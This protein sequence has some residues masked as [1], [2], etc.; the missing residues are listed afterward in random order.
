M[1][2]PG[3]TFVRNARTYSLPRG[4]SSLCALPLVLFCFRLISR[5]QEKPLME[6]DRDCETFAISNDDKIVCAV[7]HV[8]RVKKIVI[9][10]ADVW[11]ADPNGKEKLIVDSE[12]FMPVATPESY[13]V[14]TLAWSPDGSRI[15]MSMTTEK[16]SSEEDRLHR[17]RERSRCLMTT[18]TKSK[19]TDLKTR[20]IEDAANATWLAGQCKRRRI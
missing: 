10:R 14:N 5:A 17:P 2:A 13:I 11:V 12:K 1:S 9:Q 3:R 16:P 6:I 8:K 19:W 4:E 18:A 7:P 15:A 20:F